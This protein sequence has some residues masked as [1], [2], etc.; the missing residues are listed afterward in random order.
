[1]VPPSSA[2]T[3]GTLGVWFI[4]FL[5]ASLSYSNFNRNDPERRPID[6]KKLHKHYD[7][8]VV[9]AGSAGAVVANRLSENPD[10]RVLLL[11]AGGDESELS[12]IPVM[13]AYLQLGNMDW[14][15]KT[16]PQP[17][18]ACLGHV[19][20]QCNWPRGKV[21]GGS[22]V[23]NYMLYVRGNKRD[24]D[25]WEADGN[26]GWGYEE[27]LKYFKKSEDNRNPYLAANNRYH[28]TGGYLTVQESP[29]RTPLVTAFLE[30]GEFY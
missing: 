5:I 25:N 20:Q 23:L 26:P 13:A 11:E 7:F 15:Y 27:V 14:K 21:L 16:L 6:M 17:G 4:P 19:N 12:D 3:I 9:G 29:W 28:A 10:W 22:S 2:G 8:I 24:Y 30:A 18:R 1:M